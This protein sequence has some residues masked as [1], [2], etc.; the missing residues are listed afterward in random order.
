ADFYGVHK[1]KP[2]YEGLL[3]FMSSGPSIVL[4]LSG[5]D[6]ITRWRELMGA[7]NP[8]QAAGGTIRK[9]YGASAQRNACHGSDAPE[10]AVQEVEFFFSGMEMS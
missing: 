1:G 9:L 7:T 3:E 2:F 6:A 4:V 10:T 8:E 5:E